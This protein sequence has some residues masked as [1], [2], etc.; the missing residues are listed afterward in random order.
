MRHRAVS[1]SFEPYNT[2]VLFQPKICK[3][4]STVRHCST[5]PFHQV[6]RQPC[7]NAANYRHAHG[8][9]SLVVC[10]NAHPH[11]RQLL[12]IRQRFGFS[13]TVRASCYVCT[14]SPNRRH[15]KINGSSFLA[16][17]P[18]SRVYTVRS[19][20][21]VHPSPSKIIHGCVVLLIWR[22]GV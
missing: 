3:K 2:I 12:T 14:D 15:S 1:P 18:T 7:S 16:L 10:I 19:K 5:S 6:P 21:P 4:R 17:P 8:P 13:T 22:L 9:A 11:R 20:R